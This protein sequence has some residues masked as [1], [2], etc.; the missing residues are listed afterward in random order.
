[1]IS[2]LCSIALWRV[3][4]FLHVQLFCC[5]HELPRF[6]LYQHTE[7]L[8]SLKFGCLWWKA[9]TTRA[10]LDFSRLQ[11]HVLKHDGYAGKTARPQASVDVCFT[12]ASILFILMSFHSLISVTELFWWS[13]SD[14]RHGEPFPSP[15]LLVISSCFS[16]PKISVQICGA[17]TSLQ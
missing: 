5:F 13:C 9:N 6:D 10:K 1:M 15:W 11:F 4:I 14:K 16:E 12:A 8:Y 2:A 7:H 17:V 3:F